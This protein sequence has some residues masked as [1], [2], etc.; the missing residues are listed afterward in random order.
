MD[1]SP[2]AARISGRGI[3]HGVGRPGQPVRKPVLWL[4]SRNGCLVRVVLGFPN[5]R[6]GLRQ[7]LLARGESGH[8]PRPNRGGSTMLSGTAQYGQLHSFTQVSGVG[9]PLGFD[10]GMGKGIA[11]VSFNDILTVV[12]NN[13]PPTTPV[14]LGFKRWM[15]PSML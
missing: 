7:R 1:S 10:P 6:L 4:H 15:A 3:R 13:V 9:N 12:D 5:E 2:R 14:T 8:R 11:T